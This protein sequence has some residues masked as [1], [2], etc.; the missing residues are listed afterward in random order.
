MFADEKRLGNVNA[1]VDG[2][3]QPQSDGFFGVINGFIQSVTCRETT[4]K[5]RNDNTKSVLFVTGLNGNEKL[6]YF[7]RAN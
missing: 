6:H 1:A 2:F 4:W 5:I 3:F 7:V